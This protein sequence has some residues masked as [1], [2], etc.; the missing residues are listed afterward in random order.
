L[1]PGTLITIGQRY[2]VDYPDK[3]SAVDI[4][5]GLFGV[6]PHLEQSYRCRHS[7]R[8]N[9]PTTLTLKSKTSHIAI[10]WN[11]LGLTGE[12]SKK[13]HANAQGMPRSS[14]QSLRLAAQRD[15]RIYG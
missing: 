12:Q 6:N 13:S 10:R 8:H 9:S 5:R 2:L 14:Y 3:E 1:C 4:A 11:R 15:A 7:I